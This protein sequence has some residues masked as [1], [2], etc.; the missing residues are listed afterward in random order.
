MAMILLVSFIMLQNKKK[1]DFFLS[2]ICS[3]RSKLFVFFSIIYLVFTF[4]CFNNLI[5][6]DSH[7]YFKLTESIKS[8]NFSE[9]YYQRTP[10]YPFMLYLINLVYSGP[11]D[12]FLLNVFFSFC[13][14]CLA[15]S[16]LKKCDVK[17]YSYLI[18]LPFLSP[19]F[20]TYQ[21]VF[22]LES[23][24]S[25]FLL[26]ITWASMSKIKNLYLYYLN[27]S[28]VFVLA[29]YYKPHFHYFFF[30]LVPAIVFLKGT[31]FS[32]AFQFK[33]I[34]MKNFN[35]IS[36]P[37]ISLIIFL[38]LISPWE[39]QIDKFNATDGTMNFFPL[40]M[41]A[42][43]LN[44][45]YFINN[46]YEEYKNLFNNNKMIPRSGFIQSQIY[47]I[48]ENSNG[49]LLK[50]SFLENFPSYLSAF[51]K[52]F[53]EFI[54]SDQKQSENYGFF[55]SVSNVSAKGT[56]IDSVPSYMSELHTKV[57]KKYKLNSNTG[58]ISKIFSKLFFVF[59]LLNGFLMLL[60]P[61]SL[62]YGVKTKNF[63]IVILSIIPLLY[64]FIHAA[65][66]M[67]AARYSFPVIVLIYV[68]G[69]VFFEKF[70]SE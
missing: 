53:S 69:I 19:I 56:Q 24:L 63:N 31:N 46:G 45:K 1:I 43:P 18:I 23:G 36:P 11:H 49:N 47:P 9:W 41:G 34:S 10:L 20:I 2:L 67:S 3:T 44:T 33:K 59:E 16:I 52:T 50:A 29:Y 13:S 12:F 17:K 35:I 32:F 7:I 65:A 61:I 15:I 21:H 4:S 66:L 51:V 70:F 48:L 55:I 39:K 40:M 68:S 8:A 22:L 5:T 64:L 42:V 30:L 62:F 25:F 14:F 58:F 38:C 26:L 6:F 57:S 54:F 28:A 27:L 37:S 60:L